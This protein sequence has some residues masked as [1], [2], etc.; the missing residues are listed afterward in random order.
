[1]LSVDKK[2]PSSGLFEEYFAPQLRLGVYL[3]N[4][5][6]NGAVAS[7]EE[8]YF[9]TIEPAHSA[10]QTPLAQGVDRDRS[11]LLAF[12]HDPTQSQL[13]VLGCRQLPAVTAT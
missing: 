7:Q 11:C 13:G 4:N 12:A 6:V 3:C 5:M 10:D 9:G 2:N 1:M 8:R